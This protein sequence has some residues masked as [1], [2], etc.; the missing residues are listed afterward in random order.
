MTYY[1]II[2]LQTLL[3]FLFPLVQKLE[4]HGQPPFLS[5]LV[6]CYELPIGDAGISLACSYAYLRHFVASL[7]LNPGTSSEMP[8]S[9]D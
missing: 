6:M 9:R 5:L 8:V 2:R 4:I 7:K 1:C 3:Y